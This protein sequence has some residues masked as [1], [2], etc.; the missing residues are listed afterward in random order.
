MD[1]QQDG[2]TGALLAL[3][4]EGDEGALQRLFD[5]LYAELHKTASIA[6]GQQDRAAGHTLQPT[7]LV[8]E[9]FIRL[10]IGLDLTTIENRR[11][12]FGIASR[13]M[14]Q[15]LIE[16]HRK[17]SALKR[18]GD[19]ERIPLDDMLDTL[20]DSY[21]VEIDSLHEALESLAKRSPFQADVVRRKFFSGQTHSEIAC[22]LGC[23]VSKVED[24]WRIARA[25]LRR[26]LKNED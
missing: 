14:E 26:S 10:E 20:H 25:W 22:D 13:A 16:H 15:I 5:Y 18:G 6:M 8:N 12:F 4:A 24:H 3:A 19:R 1:S 21:N 17:N 2:A 7:A 11:H 9:T 23:S